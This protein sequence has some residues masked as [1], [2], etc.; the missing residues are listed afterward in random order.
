MNTTTVKQKCHRQ[1][2]NNNGFDVATMELSKEFGGVL[3]DSFLDS[4]AMAE[5][6]YDEEDDIYV[7]N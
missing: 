7:R 5:M 4:E 2:R 1:V 6:D 3:D